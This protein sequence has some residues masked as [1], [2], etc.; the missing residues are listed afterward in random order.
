MIAPIIPKK[1]SA[2]LG[3]LHLRR[4]RNSHVLSRDSG[5]VLA[6]SKVN[7]I[8]CRNGRISPEASRAATPWQ[9]FE[10][11]FPNDL[12]QMDFKGYFSTATKGAAT[13]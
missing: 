4:A 5:I 9:R 2:G 12:W 7:S 8:L 3:G 1:P 10:Y 11:L 6:P 13:R